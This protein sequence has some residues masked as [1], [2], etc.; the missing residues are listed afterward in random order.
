[1]INKKPS[2]HKFHP[3]VLETTYDLNG[4]SIVITFLYGFSLL[5]IIDI[6]LVLYNLFLSLLG[7]RFIYIIE[8]LLKFSVCGFS[9]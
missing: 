6:N 2:W 3:K 5:W 1:M 8:R 4:W 7:F 9:C